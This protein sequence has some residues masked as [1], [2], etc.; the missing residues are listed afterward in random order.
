MMTRP[1]HIEL[2]ARPARI[3]AQVSQ[4]RHQRRHH[5]GR[6]IALIDPG[7]QNGRAPRDH[8]LRIALGQVQGGDER[9]QLAAHRR[10]GRPGVPVASRPGLPAPPRVTAG[11]IAGQVP[12]VPPGPGRRIVSHGS[13]GTPGRP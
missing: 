12:P 13:N 9:G 4:A 6:R 11:M 1:D 8:P 7:R 5:R 3:L 2:A 10:D